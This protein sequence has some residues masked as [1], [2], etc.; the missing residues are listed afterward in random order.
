MGNNKKVL[1][2]IDRELKDRYR[3]KKYSKS[4][5]ATNSLFAPN[6][7]FSKP[8]KR[9]I[10]NPNAKYFKH[11]GPHDPPEK[12]KSLDEVTVTGSR[13]DHPSKYYDKDGNLIE[14]V[15]SYGTIY[16]SDP[17][18]PRIQE[19]K[20]RLH[21]YNLSKKNYLDTQRRGIDSD[22]K[23]LEEDIEY[24]K[25]AGDF[26]FAKE[27]EDLIKKLI[28]NKK[29]ISG[30]NYI[31][32]YRN[33]GRI[34]AGD[35]FFDDAISGNLN[36]R[37]KNYEGFDWQNRFL[38]EEREEEILK[39]GLKLGY[40]PYINYSNNKGVA[41]SVEYPYPSLTVRYAD[42]EKYDWAKPVEEEPE[43]EIE[44]LSFIE[45]ELIKQDATLQELVGVPNDG[46]VEDYVLDRDGNIAGSVRV[47]AGTTQNRRRNYRKLKR[48]KL[49]GT[50]GVFNDERYD[51]GGFVLE[52]D[53]N[54]ALEY[55]KNGY[56]VEMQTGGPHDPPQESAEGQRDWMMNYIQSPMYLKRLSKEFP[57]YSNE[58]LE[59]ERDARLKNV[60]NVNIKYPDKPL[61]DYFGNVSGEYFPKKQKPD[62]FDRNIGTGKLTKSNHLSNKKGN[63]YLE[64]EYRQDNWNPDEGFNTIPLHELG[65]AADDGG[66]RIP[67]KTEKLIYDSTN[68]AYEG[69]GAKYDVPVE[70][71][72]QSV[73]SDMPFYYKNNPTEFVNRLI[74]LRY[75]LERAGIWKPGEEDF[76]DGMYNLMLKNPDVMKNEY[77]QDV[78]DSIPGADDSRSKRAIVTKLL[79]EIALNNA[80]QDL[81]VAKHGGPH[82]PP[83]GGI[84]GLMQ[85][86][87]NLKN[88]KT[89]ESGRKLVY[90]EPGFEQQQ[91]S[92]RKDRANIITDLVP[93]IPTSIQEVE[94]LVDDS[95]G[96]PQ[97]KARDLTEKYAKEGEDPSDP[98]RHIMAAKLTADAIKN[99]TG[100]IPYLSQGLGWL[101]SN[102]LGVGHE[103]GTIFNDDRD[104][105]V[106]FR[107]AAEDI[108]NNLTG[109]NLSFDRRSNEFVTRDVI[110]NA[111][112]GLYPDGYGE[113][114]PFKDNQDWTD[115]YELKKEL[116]GGSVELGDEV[117]EATMQRLKKQGYTFEEI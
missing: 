70:S 74:P 13:K 15:P 91:E 105:T 98:A 9:R 64:P 67:Y 14:N 114:H 24:L 51:Q 89:I 104:F 110:N 115:P 60:Q 55:A 22:I 81:N 8:S 25:N 44:K 2:A 19:F 101:G 112:D 73:V 5:S 96:N 94:K 46:L 57:D 12:S 7:L 16:T 33:A 86:Q 111:N 3:S 106:K 100:N 97:Q 72:A 30:K 90:G 88:P 36:L 35:D 10:Y 102:A 59:L 69:L 27:N 108:R 83:S 48:G 43:I 56:I 29:N 61:Q 4:L 82:D 26:D 54:E 53:E 103:L 18:D 93:N 63:L 78:L 45:P 1:K 79:N 62:S 113:K 77:I 66:Y 32:H 65:H 116:D 76:I 109:S 75:E 42:P 58:E 21:L 87:K 107:E 17:N 52:L 28:Q 20:D 117:D 11:G 40:K 47:P 95:L 84:S 23:G 38:N 34:E 6:Y 41:L 39:E 85:F 49:D 71:Y 92:I 99:K 31:N 50:M 80:E 68:K 37:D